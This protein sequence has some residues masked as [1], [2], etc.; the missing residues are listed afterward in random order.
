MLRL[1]TFVLHEGKQ[2]VEELCTLAITGQV[3]ELRG[4][5]GRGG[6]GREGGRGWVTYTYIQSRLSKTAHGV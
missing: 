4:R 6:A 2:L 1:R 5:E 3:I